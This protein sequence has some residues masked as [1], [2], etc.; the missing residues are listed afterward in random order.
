MFVLG[1]NDEGV[2]KRDSLRTT[3]PGRVSGMCVTEIMF[4][5]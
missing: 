4:C 2:A 3:G 5:S 1:K